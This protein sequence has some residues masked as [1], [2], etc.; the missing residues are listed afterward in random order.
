MTVA[1]VYQGPNLV[2]NISR[3]ER[4]AEL[5]F[6]PG[7]ALKNGFL[8]THLPES[9]T[10]V[11]SVDSHP[12]FLNL[13]PEGAR[14]QLLLDAARS[15]D[16]VLG[17]LLKLGWDTIGDVAV[18]PHGSLMSEHEVSVPESK[19]SEVSFWDLFYSGVGEKADSAVPGVQEKISSSTI[20]FGLRTAS[21]PSAILK[22]NPNRFPRLVHNE[23]F[24]LRMARACGL[25]TCRAVLVYDRLGEPG[26]LVSR[27]DRVKQGK[28]VVKLHQ[29]DA[30]Q[31]LNYPPSAKYSVSFKDIAE[32]VS[33]PSTAPA[34][35]VERLM[36]L[37][38][39]SYIIGNSDLHAKN[40]SLIWQD[41]IRLCP[42]YD[43]LSTLP[44][45][46][47]QHMALPLQG[48]DDNFRPGD[49]VAF[50]QKYGVTEKATR[51]MIS[52]LCTRARTWVDRLDEI[53]FDLKIT[54]RM[55][56]EML[57]RIQKLE[58]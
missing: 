42:A 4:G 12:F 32:V 40:V 36:R 28:Q 15:K 25:E 22:L 19:V 3:T 11:E 20:A 37:Y 18:L 53:G 13:L 45:P 2:A 52:Q 30:C 50:G 33:K 6:L 35:E 48:R 24:F 21:V 58:R 43:L 9:S 46:L 47:D 5:E 17:L 57:L 55:R 7:I 29:E 54:S 14:L 8:A 23:E 38:A 51:S 16:D 1:D 26:L 34:V 49:F 44:Y 10:P 27:F 56:S 41:A 31:L 39:F